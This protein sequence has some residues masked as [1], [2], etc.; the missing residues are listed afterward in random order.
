MTL[1]DISGGGV[2]AKSYEG[3]AQQTETPDDLQ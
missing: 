1:I 2:E 3:N